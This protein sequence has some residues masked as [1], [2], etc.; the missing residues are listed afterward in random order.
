MLRD[1]IVRERSEGEVQ[2]VREGERSTYQSANRM[3]ISPSVHIQIFINVIQ[4]GNIVDETGQ[5]SCGKLILSDAAWEQLLGRTAAQL[6]TASLEVMKYLEER[7]LFLR[8][9][10][11]FMLHLGGED[12]VGRLAIWCVKE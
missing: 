10:L 9:T 7:L 6:V 2:T 1:T 4:L 3:Y 12:E 8:V 5:I 11:G